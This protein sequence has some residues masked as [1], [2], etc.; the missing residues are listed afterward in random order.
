MTPGDV[1]TFRPHRSHLIIAGVLSL[2][3]HT[4]LITTMHFDMAERESPALRVIEARLVPMKSVEPAPEAASP[5]RN[6]ADGAPRPRRAAPLPSKPVR[7]AAPRPETVADPV[8]TA[9]P[10]PVVESAPAGPIPVEAP[11]AMQPTEAKAAAMPIMPKRIVMHFV[12][13]WGVDG[14]GVGKAEYRWARDGDRY[15]LQSVTESTGVI[16]LFASQKLRQTSTGEVTDAGLRP[17]L[18]VIHRGTKRSDSALFDWSEK[19]LKLVDSEKIQTVALPAGAQD[20]MSV[21][22]QF[23][24]TPPVAG[25]MEFTVV[26]GRKLE[27]YRFSVIGDETLPTQW[28]EVKTLHIRRPKTETDDGMDVWLAKNQLFLPVKIR[29][30]QRKDSRP[31]EL[32]AS[33]I[34]VASEEQ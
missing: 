31:I 15:E 6:E 8:V 2:A 30:E 27:T 7:P 23:A 10:A 33:E 29:S 19:T 3:L 13:N 18:F 34:L 4:A 25:D 32:V 11:L 5:A 21:L 20:I 26:N 9:E 12:V 17:E 22:F 28:G 16:A 1:I 14:P 24:F